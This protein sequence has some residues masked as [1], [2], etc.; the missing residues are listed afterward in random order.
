MSPEISVVISTYNREKSLAGAIESILAQKNTPSFE[1][2]VVDNRSTDG[3][4]ELI[5][6]YETRANRIL[7]YV[8]ESRQGVSYGRNAG[9]ATAE[10]PL[11]AFTDDDVIVAD[12]WLSSLKNAFEEQLECGCIGG[13][14]LALW[15]EEPPMWLTE[16]H[17]APLA[18]LDYGTAQMLDGNNRK[19]LI[20]ANMGVRRTVFDE[21]GLFRPDF[22]KTAGSTCSLEDRELQERFW[23]AGGRC[24]FDPRI[25]VH[26]QIQPFRLR[27]EYHR[28]WHLSHGELHAILR[29]PEFEQSGFRAFGV[30]GHVWRRLAAESLHTAICALRFRREQAFEHELEARFFAGFIRKRCGQQ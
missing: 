12:D 22:Q 9:I 23:K 29:D 25:V 26:A 5:R 21:I 11:I 1:L 6:E 24:W 27:R 16:R 8:F 14:V 4:R 30:P 13:K 10:A 18:L 2:V 17:W 19:C 20:T 7:R 3:T 28:R 15:P